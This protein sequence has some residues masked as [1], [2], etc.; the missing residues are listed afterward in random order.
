M[1]LIQAVLRLP[2]FTAATAKHGKYYF[3]PFSSE[4]ILLFGSLFIDDT[5]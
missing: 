5:I 1:N 3:R 2:L 4:V